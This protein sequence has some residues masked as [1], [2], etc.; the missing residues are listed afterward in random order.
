MARI[1]GVRGVHRQSRTD[2]QGL[3]HARG[4]RLG[5][6]ARHADPSVRHRAR[7]GT[8]AA[9][10]PAFRAAGRL[11]RATPAR[12]AAG[13]RRN[14]AARDRRARGRTDGCGRERARGDRSHRRGPAPRHARAPRDDRALAEGRGSIPLPPADARGGAAGERP[15]LG[16]AHDV[17]ARVPARAVARRAAHRRTFPRRPRGVGLRAAPHRGHARH[18]CARDPARRRARARARGARRGA[19]DGGVHGARGVQGVHPRSLARHPPRE[20]A[21]DALARARRHRATADRDRAVGE[22]RLSGRERRSCPYGRSTRRARVRGARDVGA[23]HA[24]R[25]AIA[26]GGG[27]GDGGRARRALAGDARVRAARRHAATPARRRDRG[28][29]RTGVVGRR[30]RFAA[31][32]RCRGLRWRALARHRGAR[33]GAR[34]GGARTHRGRAR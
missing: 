32:S 3:P 8:R 21:A 28:R 5:Y 15:A 10:G 17:L 33:L 18:G 14:A 25:L 29:T 27:D 2:R 13:A 11:A 31:R 19:R 7:I 6:P 9:V 20:P 4:T 26:R 12:A 34:A 22:Q 23:R 30:T 1:L 24:A 16:C